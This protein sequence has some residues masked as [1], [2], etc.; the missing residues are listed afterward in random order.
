MSETDD[1]L[2]A[3]KEKDWKTASN[4]LSKKL[5]KIRKKVGQEQRYCE[6]FVLAALSS[7]N[8]QTDKGVQVFNWLE[9]SLKAHK[10]VTQK[11]LLHLVRILFD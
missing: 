10:E 11:I 5:K 9:K 6:Y 8:L 4:E 1:G 3:F 7:I 2:K